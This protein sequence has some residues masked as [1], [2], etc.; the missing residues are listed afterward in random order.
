MRILNEATARRMQTTLYTPDPRLLGT[1]YGFFDWSDNGQRILGHSGYEPPM[2][3][4]LLLLPDQKLGVFVAYN[5]RDAKGLTAQ[6]SGFQRGFLDHYYPAPA[7]APIRPPANFAERADRFVGSY[8]ESSAPHTTIAKLA[9]FYGAY[10]ISSPGDGTLLLNMKGVELRFVEAEPLYFSQVDGP[11]HLIFRE[12]DAGRITHMYTD[13]V[14]QYMTV[15]LDWYETPG[16]NMV[17]LQMCA[18]MFLSMIPVAV[19]HALRSRLGG[20]RKIEPR[21]ARAATWITLGLS[22]LYLVF[23]VSLMQ[24]VM[25][26]SELHSPP[27]MFKLVLGLGVLAALLTVGALVCCAR[28]WKDGY[29][30]VAFRAYYT[31]L[32][33]AAVAFVWLMNYWNMLGWRY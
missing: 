7:V 10:D 27:L 25:Q 1:A 21:G 28:A 15:R 16:F 9:G 33:T 8:R 23:T 19:V 3:S 2:S 32:T 4:A 14:P 18:L 20:N 30:S 17:L 26:P 31:L 24:M 12:D 13:V 11:Y 6:H 5:T 29:W 22:V